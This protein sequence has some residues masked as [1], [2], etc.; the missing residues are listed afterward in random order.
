MTDTSLAET[1][2]HCLKPHALCVCAGIEPIANRIE[3][4]I[5]QHPQEQDR[6]L[7]TAR[8]ALRHFVKARL[9]IGLSWSNLG[10]LIGRPTEPGRWG[11]LYL[12]PTRLKTAARPITILDRKGEAVADQ[13]RAL[14]EL[15]GIILL[16]GSW[17]QAKALWWRN[18]WMLKLHRIVLDTGAPSRYGRLRREPRSDSVSTLEAIAFIMTR[19]E[20]RPEIEVRLLASF[21]AL[22]SKYREA[23]LTRPGQEN[24]AA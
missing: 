4:I 14:A 24:G 6:E 3:I 21:T 13:D 20:N 19:L 1:C 11:V 10:K 18:P 22:L 7:G 8:L 12:G 9:A 23:R 16:D 5:L 17:S 15:E 2:P